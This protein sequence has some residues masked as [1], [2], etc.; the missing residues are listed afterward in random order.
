[1]LP[2]LKSR[3]EESHLKAHELIDRLH[4]FNP[5]A[6]V[7]LQYQSRGLRLLF[8]SELSILLEYLTRRRTCS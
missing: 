7:Y 8:G 3:L 1:M 6:E 2:M 4:D 5:N